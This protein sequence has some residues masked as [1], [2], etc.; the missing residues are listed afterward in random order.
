LSGVRLYASGSSALRVWVASAG[1]SA[2][3][4]AALDESGAPVVSVDSLAVRPVEARQLAG[5]G[6][7]AHDSLFSL[8]WVELPA[9][10]VEQVPPRIALLGDVSAD[11]GGQRCADLAALGE[12]IDAQGVAPEVVVAVVG[13]VERSEPPI[14]A[15]EGEP[16]GRASGHEPAEE[17]DPNERPT[18][19][20]DQ[21]E[22]PAAQGDPNGLAS[23]AHARAQ[24]VLE[25]LQGWLSDE[26]LIATRLALVTRGAVAATREEQ[27][28]PAS[29]PV[30]GLVRSAQAEHPDRF[31]LVDIDGSD[32]AWSALPA[33]LAT[34]EPQLAL[35]ERTARA[36]RLSRLPAQEE[37]TA[38]TLD[39]DGTV[40]ITGGTGGLGT[41]LAR[42]L[43]TERG[44]R[45]LLLASRRGAQS[46]GWED[47]EAE[48]TAHGCEVRV[49]ACD[50]ADRDE[51]SRLV[52]AI[53][54]DRPLTAVVHA[55]GVLEDGLIESLGA[56]QLE[57]VMRPKVDAALHLHELTQRLDLAA[58][59]LFSSAAGI[60]GAPGQG[61]YAAANA[62]MDALVQWRRAQSLP[63]MALA[64]GPWTPEGGM[65]HELSD[66]DRARLRRS[67]VAPLAPAEGLELFDLAG[68][69]DEPLLIPMR[70]D[71]ATL[72][73]RARDGAI[74]AVLAGLVRM[75]AH[76]S[77][78]AVGSLARR[79]AQMPESG[80]DDAVLDFVRDEVSVVLGF[81]SRSMVQPRRAFQELGFSSLDAIE[82]RNRLTTTTGLQLPATLTFD[83]PSP[84][85]VAEYVRSR[86]TEKGVARAPIEEE[87]D[88]LEA[89]LAVLAEDEGARARAQTRLRAFNARLDSFLAGG[90]SWD[91]SPEEDREDGGMADVS[92]EEMFELIDRGFDS[93]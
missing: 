46:E 5:A 7:R 58:F 52:A 87:L 17:A 74:P 59:V 48:L 64:W 55:A 72:R 56:E 32:A 38:L 85:A 41:Q 67:G 36:P 2:L 37:S 60:L 70:I 6:R 33:L 92:D 69:L 27:P 35:R 88:K 30:W 39:P 68:G 71:T 44:A 23:V 29:A 61:N 53:P 84:A 9:P 78:D 90:E 8:E 80:W 77:R 12:A 25:L 18:G 21:D 45:H 47:L 83:H 22:Q 16:A 24:Q 19:K 31:V 54:A 79:L 42:H 11:I 66:A 50:V 4:V 62:F 34:G 15:G 13:N 40:L 28:D 20:A 91:A 43:V 49:A 75:H 10:T 65:T 1:G 76:G 14:D 73:A 51:L 86:M 57:R 3:S 26:R 81:A 82:L 63:A 89:M 93:I